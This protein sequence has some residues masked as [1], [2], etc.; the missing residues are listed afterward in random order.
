MSWPLNSKVLDGVGVI[1]D[2][3][4]CRYPWPFYHLCL[5]DGANPPKPVEPAQSTL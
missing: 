1:D 4:Y 3:D 2:S 5:K